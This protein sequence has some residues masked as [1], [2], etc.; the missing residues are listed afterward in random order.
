MFEQIFTRDDAYKVALQMAEF[1]KYTQFHIGVR[2]I[3]HLGD[4]HFIVTGKAGLFMPS[5]LSELVL[6][7]MRAHY[8]KWALEPKITQ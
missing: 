2:T 7:G 6:Y 8:N 3:I 1:A 5:E 4:G